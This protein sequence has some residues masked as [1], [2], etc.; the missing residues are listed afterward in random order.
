M[1]IANREFLDHSY[2]DTFNIYFI[3]DEHL[4]TTDCAEHKIVQYVNMIKEDPF[5]YWIG[6][7]DAGE[8]IAPDDKRWTWGKAADWLKIDNMAECTRKRYCEIYEPIRDK[9]LGR[10][11]GNHEEKFHLHKYGD[12]HQNICDSLGVANLGFSCF[13]S[14][15]FKRKNSKSSRIITGCFTHGD[16][17]ATT[18]EG[19]LKKLHNLMDTHVAN[20]YAYAHTHA[21]KVSTR[22]DLGVDIKKK[23]L[24]DVVKLGV[25]TGCFFKTYG[26]NQVPSY[27][28][29]KL[30]RALPL[31]CAVIRITPSQGTYR[32]EALI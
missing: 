13:M 30:Y 25:L 2:G 19:K 26:E 7:G 15:H 3:G 5:G 14:F 6:M 27:G 32:G 17:G 12:V 10:L 29:K 22:I 24:C 23:K 18:E 11:F 31:G 21:C 28:E 1:I 4:G 16:G 9:C 8:Y 20:I